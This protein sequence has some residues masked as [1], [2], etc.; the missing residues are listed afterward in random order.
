MKVIPR[1]K[2]ASTAAH[3]EGIEHSRWLDVDDVETLQAE[4]D[5]LVSTSPVP[6][7]EWFVVDHEG[8]GSYD[9]GEHPDL[10]WVVELAARL[11]L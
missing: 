10:D 7:V 4:V 6:S 1:I 11:R 3:N 8:F 9:L 2:V 5:D